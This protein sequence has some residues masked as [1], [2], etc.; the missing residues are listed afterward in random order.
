MEEAGDIKPL[1]YELP[2]G[3]TEIMSQFFCGFTSHA[4]K[5]LWCTV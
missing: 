1:V 2:A 5:H 3:Q 4:L